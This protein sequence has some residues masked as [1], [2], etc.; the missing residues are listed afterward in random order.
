MAIEFTINLSVPPLTDQTVWFAN[1]QAW[2][3][4][5]NS[6]DVAVATLNPVTTT[7]YAPVA[8][9]DGDPCIQEIDG[10]QYQLVQKAVFDSLVAQ[11]AALDNMFQ[12]MRQELKDAGLISEAQ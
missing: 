4:Y 6:A 5:W 1:A 9:I 2:T 8:F 11:V 3:N 12:A 7:I 10:V